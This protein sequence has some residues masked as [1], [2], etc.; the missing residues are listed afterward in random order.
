MAQTAHAQSNRE[1][2]FTLIEFLVA[3]VILLVGMLGLLQST[4]VAITSSKQNQLRN[5]AIL[6]M[7]N[8]LAQELAKGYANVSVQPQPDTFEQR[9]IL[10]AFVNYSVFRNVTAFQ[11]SKQV[12]FKVTWPYRAARY[13]YQGGGV[14]SNTVAAQ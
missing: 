8:A 11:N 13:S 5:E 10:N 4:N 7:D 1:S 12:R 14:I 9:K 3:V 2:G 6:V